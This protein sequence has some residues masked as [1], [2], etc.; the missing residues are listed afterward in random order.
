MYTPKPPKEEQDN[1]LPEWHEPFPKPQTIPDGWDLSGIPSDLT[2][3]EA[4]FEDEDL[5]SQQEA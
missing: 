2:A 1:S 3:A 4:G 5:S